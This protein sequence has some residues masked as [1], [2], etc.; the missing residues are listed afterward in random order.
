MI[1]V[2]SN[3][4]MA[5]Y[6]RFYKK[7]YLKSGDFEINIGLTLKREK[8]LSLNL[9]LNSSKGHVIDISDFVAVISG[10]KSI[11]L[12]AKRKIYH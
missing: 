10:I 3:E 5:F 4:V 11:K 6:A 2:A 9:R 12:I 8:T 1:S 7:Y